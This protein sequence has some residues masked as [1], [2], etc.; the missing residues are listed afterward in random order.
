MSFFIKA[1][2]KRTDAPEGI[3]RAV[4]IDVVDLGLKKNNFNQKKADLI[5]KI[6]ICWETAEINPQ[7]GRR[8]FAAKEYTFS[9]G[10]RAALRKDLEAWLGRQLEPGENFD[11]E[12]L[13]G[14]NC[15]LTLTSKTSQWN[16]VYTNV[17]EVNPAGDQEELLEVSSD[18]VRHAPEKGEE[19]ISN[20]KTV[21]TDDDIPF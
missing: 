20:S 6:E 2:R 3:H 21:I 7:T 5:H 19:P 8:Y 16:N 12:S 17:T 15:R 1:A 4:C 14:Q 13:I 11:L 9:L 10:E 18:E